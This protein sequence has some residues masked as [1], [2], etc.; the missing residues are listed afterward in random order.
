MVLDDIGWTLLL[1]NGCA[2]LS[3]RSF[4]TLWNRID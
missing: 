3:F 2:L 1:D 4:E